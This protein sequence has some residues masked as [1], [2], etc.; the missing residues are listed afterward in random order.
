MEQE[1]TKTGEPVRTPEARGDEPQDLIEP[2]DGSGN[3]RMVF[4]PAEPVVAD[5][6]EP[7]LAGP[8]EPPTA[9]PSNPDA[10]TEGAEG[11]ETQDATLGVEPAKEEEAIPSPPPAPLLKTS[12]IAAPTEEAPRFEETP[13]FEATL[14]EEKSESAAPAEASVSPGGVLPTAPLPWV[15][16]STTPTH[17]PNVDVLPDRA[18]ESDRSPLSDPPAPHEFDGLPERGLEGPSVV[19]EEMATAFAPELGT[20]EPARNYRRLATLRMRRMRLLRPVPVEGRSEVSPDAG[21]QAPPAAPPRELPYETG[22][23]WMLAFVCLW[24][25][26]TSLNEAW[27]VAGQAGLGAALLRNVT[28]L[29][30]GVLGLGLVG[31]ALEALQHGKRRSTATTVLTALAPALLTLAGVILLVLSNDPGR[32]I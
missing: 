28:F 19:G 12:V 31:F 10:R 23:N 24:A 11:D 8:V 7:A 14:P 21:T 26:G 20:V 5:P 3:G 25:G 22:P 1:P 32:R 15:E 17:E 18:L 6:A 9:L 2:S 16:A 13:R 27:Y 29:G 4:V 30:Y